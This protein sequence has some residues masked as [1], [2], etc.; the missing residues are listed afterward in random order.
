MQNKIKNLKN[1]N[2]KINCFGGRGN[3]KAYSAFLCQEICT[4]KSIGNLI[5]SKIV[6][7]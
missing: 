5:F 7:K 6:K 4:K 2:K 1:F 3:V